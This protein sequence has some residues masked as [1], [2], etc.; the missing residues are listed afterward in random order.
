M[1]SVNHQSAYF[2]KVPLVLQ[3]TCDLQ[4]NLFPFPLTCC[5]P[6]LVAFTHTSVH[7]GLSAPPNPSSPAS[8]LFSIHPA[9]RS[10]PPIPPRSESEAAASLGPCVVWTYCL[11]CFSLTLTT[12][13]GSWQLVSGEQTLLKMK[14]YCCEAPL[15]QTQPKSLHYV[16]TGIPLRE[17]KYPYWFTVFPGSITFSPLDYLTLFKNVYDTLLAHHKSLFG[18]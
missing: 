2:L 16:T 8:L 12:L 13:S 15:G 1:V 6:C 3:A 11:W 7:Q 17:Q 10:S 4:S 18:G 9:F 5:P 14:V